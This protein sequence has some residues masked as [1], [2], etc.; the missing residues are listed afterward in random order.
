MSESSSLRQEIGGRLSALSPEILL[1]AMGLFCA[2]VGAFLLIAPHHFQSAPYEALLPFALAWGTLALVSGMGLLAVAVLRPRRWVALA[3]HLLAALA[4]LALAFSFGRVHAVTGACVYSLLGLGTAAAGLSRRDR[5]A[6]QGGDLFALLLSLASLGSGLMILLVPQLFRSPFYG[7][8][9]G[10][11][12]VLGL[13]LAL[14]GPVLAWPQ[15]AKLS[16][17]RAWK[18]HLFPGLVLGL[19]GLAVSAPTQVWT[20]VVLYCAGGAAIAV[21]PWLR[22]RLAHIDTAALRTRLS[23]ALATATSLALVAATAVV[24]AQEERL[25]EEQAQAS[26]RVEARA[27][28]RNISDYIEMN[29]ARTATLAAFA[30]RVPMT[31]ER[32]ARFLAAS[33]RSYR[34]VSTLCTQDAEGRVVAVS[35]NVPLPLWALESFA[36]GSRD[37]T[38]VQL[39]PVMVDGRPV[40]LLSAPIRGAAGE[41]AGNLVTAFGPA[42]LAQRIGRPGARVTLRDGRGRLLA[43]RDGLRDGSPELRPLPDDWDWDLRTIGKVKAVPRGTVAGFA[44]VDH[45]AWGVAVEQPRS[46]ALAGV[47][48]GRDLAFGLL[49]LV[50][51]LTVATGIFAARRIARPLGDLSVAVGEITA[52]NLEVPIAA[53][54]GIT[55]VSSLAADFQEMRDRLA[56]RTQESERLARELRARAEALAETD[57]RKDE[58][59]AM[60]AH[61]LRNPLGAIANASYLLEQLGPADPRME[62]PVAIIRRQIQNLVRMVDDLLDVS[63]ITRGKVELRRQPL[64]LGEVLRHAAEIARPLA[65]AKDQTLLA[66]V[67]AEPLPLEGD[68]TRLEQVFSNLLRN[69]VKFTPAGGR[70]ELWARNGRG[71]A[72]VRVCDDGIGIP[73]DLLPRIFDLFTQGEQSLDRSIGGLGIGLTLVRSLVEMHGGRVE[74]HSDGPGLG[75]ELEVRLPL[76]K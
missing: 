49:L 72:V 50:V 47:R 13:A 18:A 55:E 40:L 9:R 11:M 57:R 69:A 64:D 53:A 6:D 20:G 3:A 42:A 39:T 62:R 5:P 30:G 70:I 28:A 37:G 33:R 29:G 45:L 14:A 48:Q 17:R 22:R 71:E 67:P 2:F 52:G 25:A 56:E 44:L 58:F 65:E 31:R 15:L 12:E 7:P 51:P 35:G 43:E 19:F 4:L 41:H 8:F 10:R 76:A 23:L 1:W 36:Q 66:E 34:E 74:A 27:M 60:L 73:A 46:E 59:L 32:Q 61:E 26:Q 38:G 21:L 54:S 16:R 68:A 24:T 75:S 63:R